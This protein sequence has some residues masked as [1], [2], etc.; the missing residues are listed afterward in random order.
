MCIRDRLTPGATGTVSFVVN[1]AASAPVD[2]NNSKASVT[3][4]RTPAGTHTVVATFTPS[5]GS[6]FDS[7]S[8]SRTMHV[9]RASTTSVLQTKAT[10]VK[11]TKKLRKLSVS[12]TFSSPQK[13]AV[14]GR[15]VMTLKKGAKV[16]GRKTASLK[17]GKA[18]AAFGRLKTG[19]YTVSVA[20]AGNANQLGAVKTKKVRIR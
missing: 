4:P 14:S 5:P 11:K 3:L 7:A 20:Y 12:A 8:A 18:T 17:S 19:R 1:G 15:V 2:V 6:R 13:V 16:V 10:K 9:A